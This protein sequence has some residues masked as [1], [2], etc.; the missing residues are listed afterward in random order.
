M[1][2]RTRV[3]KIEDDLAI[4][5]PTDVLPPSRLQWVKELAETTDWYPLLVGSLDISTGRIPLFLPYA[6]ISR[7]GLLPEERIEV[8]LFGHP[9]EW[10]TSH[11]YHG[12][13]GRVWIPRRVVKKL[14]IRPLEYYFAIIRGLRRVERPVR[15]V[16]VRHLGRDYETENYAP[17]RWRWIIPEEVYIRETKVRP[18]EIFNKAFELGI[19]PEAECYYAPGPGVIET[20]LIIPE[21]EKEVS[22]HMLYCFRNIANRNFSIKEID[23]YPFFCECRVQIIST[24]PR[25]WYQVRLPD[26]KEIRD[27]LMEVLETT[28]E[29][30][31]NW[32]IILHGVWL[33]GR[34]GLVVYSKAKFRPTFQAKLY[35]TANLKPRNVSFDRMRG[36]LVAKTL[37]TAGQEINE[38]IS[39]ADAIEFPFGYCYKYVRIVNKQFGYYVY[40]DSRIEADMVGSDKIWSDRFGFVWR[41]WW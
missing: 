40:D 6:N 24:Y 38:K 9:D 7:L 8:R 5:I 26:G 33:G 27:L 41:R 23:E 12:Y 37:V 29:N 2:I 30:I 20:D 28:V 35:T 11:L 14:S 19:T 10:F 34:K 4:N 3:Y 13:Q 31:L 18:T 1:G 39:Y 17:N 32:H 16:I 25:S 36:D 21:R 22:S 15:K